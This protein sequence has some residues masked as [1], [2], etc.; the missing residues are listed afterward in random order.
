MIDVDYF[1]RLNDTHGH[2][3]GDAVL[4]RLS[5]VLLDH[6]RRNDIVGRYG[7]EEIAV[8]LPETGTAGAA[9]TAER[10]R[11]AVEREIFEWDGHPVR[12]T[13]SLGVA[14]IASS[15]SHGDELVRDADRA[16]Y[17]AKQGGRNRAMVSPPSAPAPVEQ[18][19]TPTT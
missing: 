14:T 9:R 4:V 18:T 19:S 16:L 10:L 3:A 8:L 15:T 5:T 2:Q 7:G 17:Q 6:L 1:K 13:I 12:V 11:S